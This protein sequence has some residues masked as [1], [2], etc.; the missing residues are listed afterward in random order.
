MRKTIFG[1]LAAVA[2]VLTIASPANAGHKW[3]HHHVAKQP[4]VVVGAVVGTVFGV[5]LYNGW[6]GTGVGAPLGATLGGS[7]TGGLLAG[8]GTAALIHAATT[9]C[10]GFHALLG[11]SG[12]KNG[13]YVGPKR[14]AFLFW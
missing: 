14:Q 5:G 13:K 9:P 4:A 11:G 12:C 8:I 1:I 7:I 10:V 3:R 2:V 6:W